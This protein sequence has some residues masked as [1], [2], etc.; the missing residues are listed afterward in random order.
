MARRSDKRAGQPGS[1]EKSGPR[2][3]GFGLRGQLGIAFAFLVAVAGAYYFGQMHGA[4]SPDQWGW[5]TLRSREEAEDVPAPGSVQLEEV[6]DGDTIDVFWQPSQP[7]QQRVRLAYVDT[8]ERG[9]PGYD[10]AAAF[11]R[12]LLADHPLRVE[13]D[14][15]DQPSFGRYGR[16]LAYVFVTLPDGREMLVNEALIAGGHGRY[17]REY[18]QGRFAE[19]LEAAEG[20]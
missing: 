6:I 16:L 9:Q 18:G 2:F 5:N 19:R 20:E 11:L 3:P 4:T 17:L 10:E 1:A 7:I 15:P 8:P 14:T 12:E 13:F